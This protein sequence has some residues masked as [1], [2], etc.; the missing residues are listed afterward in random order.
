VKVPFK[1]AISLIGKKSV[2]VHRGIAYVPITELL[3]ITTEH[4]R[5]RI[6]KE[7]AKASKHLPM[8]YKDSRMMD[9]LVNLSKIEHIDFNLYEPQQIKATGDK[10]TVQELDNLAQ[11][12]YPPCMKHL[13][14]ALVK[15]SHLKHWGRL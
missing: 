13:H 5:A 11:R 3:T 12:S 6:S 1:E 10:I 2:F 8:I 9:M 4:F 7:L 14:S 15:N